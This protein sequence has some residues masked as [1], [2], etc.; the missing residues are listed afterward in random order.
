MK[1]ASEPPKGDKMEKEG[2]SGGRCEPHGQG[3]E[4][5]GAVGAVGGMGGASRTGNDGRWWEMVGDCGRWWEWW[6]G[7]GVVGGRGSGG[8]GVGDS[9]RTPEG[10]QAASGGTSN[11]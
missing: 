11:W 3:W 10:G 6:E 9:P 4:V 7:V 8:S 1:L 5:V 2:G